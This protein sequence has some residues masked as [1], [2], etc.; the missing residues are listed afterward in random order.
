MGRKQSY[1]KPFNFSGRGK[2]QFP[3]MQHMLKG[4]NVKI[5]A[6]SQAILNSKD[7]GMTVHLMAYSVVFQPGERSLY[8]F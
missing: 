7:C 5:L 8:L 4:V 2:G 6:M 1:L 3:L